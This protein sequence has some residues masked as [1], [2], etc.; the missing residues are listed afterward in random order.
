MIYRERASSDDLIAYYRRKG[1]RIGSNCTF[2]APRT[3]KIDIT[4][5][6]L[7][8]IGN[9]V[10][11]TDYVSILCHDFAW[12]TFKT[13]KGEIIGSNG[14]VH[15]GNNVFI[16][17]KSIIMKGV[18]VGN[19]V[20]IGAG[21]VVKHDIPDCTVVAGNPAKIIMTYDEFYTKRKKNMFWR[22]KCLRENILIV[23]ASFLPKIY[24]EIFSTFL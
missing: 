1:I 19:N 4:Q 3:I 15:I 24:S 23:K 18:T 12:S 6:F 14:P 11:I 21:S 16:G 8:K 10:E 2:H 20:I 5:P 17:E 7:I 22:R 13:E 9:N